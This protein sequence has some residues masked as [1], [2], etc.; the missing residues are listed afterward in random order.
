M[1][2]Q[3]LL[4]LIT[5][6]APGEMSQE[7][8]RFAAGL[9]SPA[10]EVRRVSLSAWFDPAR[11]DFPPSA[12]ELRRDPDPRVRAAALEA[13]ALQRPQPAETLLLAALDDTDLSV[14]IAAIGALGKFGTPAARSA[15]EKL[16]SHSHEAARVASVRALYKLAGYQAVVPSA[17]DKSWRVRQAV[18]ES[19]S[20]A[21][22]E[23]DRLS[24]DTVD[25]ARSLVHDPSLDVQRQ[26]LQSLGAWPLTK[27]GALLLS[28]MGEAGYQTRKD[29]AAQLT[30]RWPAAAEFPVEAPAAERAAVVAALT[31]RW[32]SEFQ[33][34]TELAVQ[35]DQ[36]SH[37]AA[38]PAPE[39]LA[40]LRS[41]LDALGDT[42]IRAAMRQAALDGLVAYGAALP[43]ALESPALADRGPLPEV[44]YEEVL[45]KVSPVFAALDGLSSG[46]VRLRR[47]G[48]MQLSTVM[49]GKPMTP[50]ALDRL[51]VFARR[52]T[53]P[54]VWQ[55]LLGAT[56]AD[57]RAGAVQL[58]YLAVGNSSSDVRR[59]ACDYLAAHADVRHAAVL[60]PMLED[61]SST[62]VIAAVRGLGAIGTMEDP[63][64]LI[65]LLLT[66]DREL[67]LE[68]ATN[69]VRLKVEDGRAA[70]QRM[71]LDADQQLRLEVAGRMGELAEPVFVPT[72]IQMS[73]EP[74]DV[75]RV[76]LE[77]LAKL[78]GQNFSRDSEGAIVPRDVQT[79]QW[80]A[81]YRRQELAGAVPA[82]SAETASAAAKQDQR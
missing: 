37:A 32:N 81:W 1:H 4:G 50:L 17:H 30:A 2:A 61:P 33:A 46:D 44:V 82:V 6:Q 35:R 69:L 54:V 13:I 41:L 12:L 16:R 70:M 5:T 68:V 10:I 53:D 19:L 80:Q 56:A 71:A 42:E 57:A 43:A 29:A 76:A 73:A 39:D 51:V 72:L 59:R 26:M 78:T 77:S 7:N 48:A 62:V 45:P 47:G 3:V 63:R 65:G 31:A 40:R 38:N 66:P 75:G 24:I 49:A 9:A 22:E 74:N 8:F 36:Q 27:S 18:A 58:A 11:K 52:E 20:Q 67:R 34:S 15:L 60:L 21:G 14:R 55:C 25:L 23:G 28:A 79:A 64:P